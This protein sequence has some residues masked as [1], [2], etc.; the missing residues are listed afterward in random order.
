MSLGHESLA[1]FLCWQTLSAATPLMLAGIGELVGELTGVIDIGIEG[2]MLIGCIVAYTAA[3]ATGQA[4]M[5]L[6]AAAAAGMA[7]AALFAGVVL[8]GR[9]D[10]I[11]AGAALNLLAL[12]FSAT[13]WSLYQNHCANLG[14]STH[15]PRGAGYDLVAVPGL[16]HLPFIGPVLFDQYTLFY[17]TLL[18]AVG[19]WWVLR[20]TRLGLMIRALGESPETCVA[21]GIP[22]R[23]GRFLAALFAG[24]CAGAAGA[25][26]SIMRTKAFAFDMTG[27]QGFMVLALVIFGRWAI[28][29]LVLGCLFF[30][31]INS[32]QQ[33][34]QTTRYTLA[35]SWMHALQSV[36][37]EF[38]QMLPYVAALAALALLS[39]RH[40]GPR[41]LGQ[42]WPQEVA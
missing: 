42:P 9:A 2:L 30:G 8:W 40:P 34:L 6:G 24:G 20:F 29:P 18:L 7:S 36:P 10:Q 27:G 28:G 35:D 1:E 4:W 41:A 3:A 17:A 14:L 26:L 32:L 25:F 22:V 33:I 12:G 11:V 15:L 21:C 37:F 13:L 16:S 19:I 39:R 5:G 38:F 23:L 31:A